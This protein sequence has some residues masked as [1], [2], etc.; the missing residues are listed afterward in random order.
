MTTDRLLDVAH[1]ERVRY[2]TGA[3]LV[4]VPL[5][6]CPDCDGNLRLD[7]LRQDTLFRG[8]G[9][10]GTKRVETWECTAC[11]FSRVVAVATE[12]PPR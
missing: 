9:Y 11:R 1:G 8:G 3:E 4:A 5:E 12:R 7:L 2:H 10:G 6:R